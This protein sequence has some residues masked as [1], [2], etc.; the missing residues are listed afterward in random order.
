MT[1]YK[2]DE[3]K[4]YFRKCSLPYRVKMKS[5]KIG[6][7]SFVNVNRISVCTNKIPDFWFFSP[8][9]PTY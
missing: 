5:K 8:P 7:F 6:A 1:I 4:T 2:A 9:Y 3:K